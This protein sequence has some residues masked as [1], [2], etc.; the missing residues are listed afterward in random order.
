[1]V[2][3]TMRMLDGVHSNTSHAGPVLLLG[4][5]LVV[6]SVSLK[7]GLVSSLTAGDDTNH[8]SAETLDGLS[9][10]G[11]KS[12]SGLL[13]IFGVADDDTGSAGSASNAATVTNLSLNV[14]DDGAFGHSVDGEDVA[15]GE[16]RLGSSVDEHAGVH[17]FDRDEILS[18]LLVFVL[19]SE[20]NFGERGAS[21]GVVHNV[22][23]NSLD[24]ALRLGEVQGS[25]AGGG[26]SLASV[27]SED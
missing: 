20:N 17:A 22:L 19:V 21:A 25:E 8:S 12:Q 2:T 15:N 5:G 9:D 16:R 27:G 11:R 24:V 7:K 23:H 3:T 18:A 26:N 10:T 14:G 13:A 6:G 4:L 1:M